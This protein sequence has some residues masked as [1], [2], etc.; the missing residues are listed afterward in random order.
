[1]R[2]SIQ[3]NLTAASSKSNLRLTTRELAVKDATPPPILWFLSSRII[4]LYPGICKQSLDTRSLSHVSVTAKTSNPF[5]FTI[6]EISSNLSSPFKLLAFKCPNLK[7]GHFSR[8]RVLGWPCN[9][10][11]G[12]HGKRGTH[13]CGHKCFPVCSRAQHLLRTQILCPGHKKCF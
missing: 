1:M 13:C 6:S 4:G 2:N 7:K 5:S 3:R 9:V 8:S 11:W 10:Y 12:G